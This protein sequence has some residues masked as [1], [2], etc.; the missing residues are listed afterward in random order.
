MSDPCVT[1]RVDRKKGNDM[2]VYIVTTTDG[3]RTRVVT[4][5]DP[6][7]HP[8]FW[9]RVADVETIGEEGKLLS[10]VP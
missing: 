2:F 1:L 9:G 3:F 4:D 8:A 5:G 7:D 6:T 10:L